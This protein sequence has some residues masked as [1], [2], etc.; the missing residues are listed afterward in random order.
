MNTKKKFSSDKIIVLI[1]AA[2]ALMLMVGFILKGDGSAPVDPNTENVVLTDNGEASSIN[3]DIPKAGA[4]DISGRGIL[5]TY[6]KS[7][8]DSLSRIK[9]S[10]KNNF[11]NSGDFLQ[12]NN[13]RLY[14]EEEDPY[15]ANIQM[16]LM[17]ME[18]QNNQIKK[19]SNYSSQPSNKKQGS[20]SSELSDKIEYQKLLLE[21]RNARMGRSQ[22]Y[23]SGNNPISGSIGEMNATDEV[24]EFRASIYKDQLI[25]PGERVVLILTEPLIYKNQKFQKNTLLYAVTSI[26]KNRLLLDILNINHQRVNLEAVDI[27]DGIKGIY[28]VK[29]GLLWEKYESEIQ[30]DVIRDVGTAIP[31]RAGRFA[32]S[33]SRAF[34]SFFKKKKISNRDKILLVSD[35]QVILKTK[36]DE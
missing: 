18:Q 23:S 7:T 20:A 31:G 1:V 14:Q 16:Q 24:I 35:D 10:E 15:V 30:E 9:E 19:G 28:N 6:A 8:R 17:E 34:G 36:L 29:A 22:D 33:V 21:A 13:A 11:G 12:S 32:S 4:K 26:D 25:I 2:V 5:D 3:F 27:D